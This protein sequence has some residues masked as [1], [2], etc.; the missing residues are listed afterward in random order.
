MGFSE[1]IEGRLTNGETKKKLEMIYKLQPEEIKKLLADAPKQAA[2]Y[3][4][5]Y[6]F[7]A[8]SMAGMPAEV[9]YNIAHQLIRAYSV[10]MLCLADVKAA[11][12][13]APVSDAVNKAMAATAAPSFMS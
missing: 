10:Y 2:D 8:Q 12:P 5:R 6:T 13:N 4:S 9:Q 3:V 7:W 11:M 1:T